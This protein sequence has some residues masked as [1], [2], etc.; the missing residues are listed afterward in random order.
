ML[1]ALRELSSVASIGGIPGIL[2]MLGSGVGSCVMVVNSEGCGVID[3]E[4]DGD[5][6]ETKVN[7]AVYLSVGSEGEDDEVSD[8]SV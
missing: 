8:N 4:V 5:G 7:K 3:I 6:D 1:D 2:V